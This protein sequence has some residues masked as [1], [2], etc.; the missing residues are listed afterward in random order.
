MKNK[1]KVLMS[2][3][4]MGAMTISQ[5]IVVKAIAPGETF[6]TTL[7]CGEVEGSV[8]IQGSNVTI[9]SGGNWC[10][11][12]SS[13]SVKVKAG[14]EGLGS[15]SL[16][17]IDAIK[18][19]S[20]NPEPLAS[21]AII[22][23]RSFTFSKPSSGG[24]NSGGG[25]SSSSNQQTPQQP[26]IDN[27]S[28]NNLLASLSVSEGTLSPTFKSSITEYTVNLGKDVE[29]I[30]VKASASDSKASVKGTG[31]LKVQ[32]GEN[33]IKITV[34]AE[35]GNP[36]VYTIKAIVDESPVVFTEF[37]GKQLGVVRNLAA[38]PQLDGFEKVKVKIDEKEVNAWKSPVRNIT[39]VYLQN[40]KNEKNFYIYDE[41]KGVT[42]K[43]VL[44]ALYGNNLGIVD[45]PENLQKRAGMKYGEVHL[46]DKT[47]MG[48]TYEDPAF[49]NYSLIYAM[50]EMG[51]YNY[52]QFESTQNTLQ[53]YSNA[54]AATQKSYDEVVQQV[55]K[56]S[57][58]FY[59]SCGAAV[60]FLIVAILGFVNAN[61]YKKRVLATSRHSF[62]KG[63]N[64]ADE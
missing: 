14:A 28:K 6:S 22:D 37:N 49:K 59:I 16:V 23:S 8:R 55:D 9:V 42:S 46:E 41:G 50:D 51:K 11:R 52:Y 43:Y 56:M 20:T 47:L 18:N 61:K 60:L 24:G 53:I 10:D 38:V 2:L 48:W 33:K 35:N 64:K 5:S 62:Q 17:A 4:L 39:L 25:N 1:F 58:Y 57:M 26:V 44:M 45:I 29:K 40:E 12:G 32:P 13:I 54:A 27:R 15:I 63:D 19:P 36:K 31:V 34:T 7:V 30:T 21:G 3:V